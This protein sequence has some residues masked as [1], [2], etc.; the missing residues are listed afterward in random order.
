LTFERIIIDIAK[1]HE[2]NTN[3]R[4]LKQYKSIAI[5]IFYLQKGYKYLLPIII[6]HTKYDGVKTMEDVMKKIIWVT[7]GGIVISSV[8]LGLRTTALKQAYDN[9]AAFTVTDSNNVTH[10]VAASGLSGDVTA[11]LYT[12][13]AGLIMLA[14]V[15]ADI[16][17]VLKLMKGKQ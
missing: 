9:A 14:V 13:G 2:I 4:I 12:I 11:T 1:I 5:Y 17:L 6:Y 3:F 7:I 8:L 16:V 15:I 10:T